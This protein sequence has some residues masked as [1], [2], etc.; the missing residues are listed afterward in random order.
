MAASEFIDNI[1]SNYPSFLP[2]LCVGTRGEEGWPV[3]DYLLEVLFVANNAL[4]IYKHINTIQYNSDN[5]FQR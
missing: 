4:R 5:V 1:H 2:Y 3:Q